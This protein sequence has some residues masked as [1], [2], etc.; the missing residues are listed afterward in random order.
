MGQV[1]AERARAHGP[2]TTRSGVASVNGGDPDQPTL[3]VVVAS[4]TR[5][6]AE[7]PGSPAPAALPASPI[8]EPPSPSRTP[9]KPPASL[10]P[11][12]VTDVLIN[13]EL[14]WLDFNARVLAQVEDESLPL[15]ERARFLAIASRAL[16]EFFQ[17]RVGGL[18]QLA[19]GLES[20]A[21]DPQGPQAQVRAIRLK[22]VE[23]YA[24]QARAFLHGLVPHLDSHGI[25]FSDWSS[26]DEDDRAYL[27]KVF[28]ERIFPVLTPLA[29]DP[30]HPFPYISSLSLNLMVVVVD[31]ANHEQR[32]ARIKVPPLLSRFVVLP[33]GERFVPIEQV[34]A[35]HLHPL[36][37]GMRVVAHH[38]FRLTRN[39]DYTIDSD[40]ADDLVEAVR[41]IL[42]E[43]RRSPLVVR[44][45]V[46]SDMPPEM[47][48]LLARELEIQHQD[49][50]TI[51][52]PLDLGGLFDVCK[53]DRP[54]LKF[55]SWVPVTPPRFAHDLG[56]DG[57]LFRVLREDQLL[58]HHP[59]DSFEHTVEAFI[60]QAAEDPAVLAIKQTL[61]R[62]SGPVSPIIRSLT[63]AA[64]AGKQVVAMVELTARFDEQN[65]I[66]WAEVL[67]DAGVHV[68]YGTVG[69]KTHAKVTLVVRE[70]PGGIR[71]YCHIGTGNYNR[72]T[73]RNY[74]DM[75]LL[76]SDPALGADV[77]ELF[78][79]LTGYSRQARYRKLL[80]APDSMRPALLRLVRRE[81]DRG[82][83]GRIVIKVNNLV[84]PEMI[85]AL[86]LASQA[87][88]QI[89][90]IVRSICCL[91]PGVPGLT[92][93]IRVRS[94]VGRY[95]EHSR[96]LRF[97][98]DGKDS[99][100][101]ISS[102]DLMP[103]NLDR[104]VEA[105]VP[106]R[107]PELRARLDQVLE[108]NLSDDTLAW[109]LGS[110]GEWRRA[111]KGAGVD[112]QI[113]LQEIALRR[114]EGKS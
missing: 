72:D 27:D 108:I 67:E 30:G 75:G 2:V 64:E 66:N 83:A 44:L 102:A 54:D 28:E 24:R 53:L 5:T 96:I 15:L 77:G 87:G 38:V 36:F 23:L 41:A 21:S 61:Y 79:S 7:L 104:R 99:D 10:A 46:G 17:V 34:I 25:R 43:R 4:G 105:A 112:T 33:D 50:Y 97:G 58:V 110:D 111:S 39:A 70:E 56:G 114:A 22:V 14:S 9:K 16:D 62:T 60:A 40:E 3:D 29:V 90:L 84:D 78:N 19:A 57:D 100:Y 106:I 59:Y 103:R 18:K 88:V 6:P 91:R 98:R 73:A 65:N 32:I 35:A 31:P 107:A 85:A 113:R 80:V 55:R 47:V 94:L 68:V 109:E 11:F 71:R 37:E 52:A 49:V 82:K 1:P 95:L 13:R 74:E 101:Y 69:L 86:C 89:D 76:T 92:D 93:N 20:A 8:P 26:L 48:D 51:S 42:K 12:D 45:E 81:T 63:R